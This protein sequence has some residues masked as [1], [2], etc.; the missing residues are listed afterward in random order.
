MYIEV[1]DDSS[2]DA[3]S[4]ILNQFL[5]LDMSSAQEI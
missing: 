4:V 3:L 1:I 2:H 5:I